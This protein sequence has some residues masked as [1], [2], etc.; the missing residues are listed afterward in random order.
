MRCYAHSLDGEALERWQ[1]LEE[2]S[3]N[4]TESAEQFAAGF[5]AGEWA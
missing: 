3:R 1:T 2:H 4:V 5:A